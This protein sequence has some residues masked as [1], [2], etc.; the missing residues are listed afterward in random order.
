M[1][2]RDSLI[3][4]LRESLRAAPFARAAWLGGSVATGRLDEWSDIDLFII[5]ADDAVDPTLTLIEQ[6]LA[7]IAPI[8]RRFRVPEPAWHGHSQAFY[9]QFGLP[10]HLMTDVLVMKASCPAADRFLEVERHGVPTVLFDKD[11]V[12]RPEPMNAP[13]HR[14]KVA[15]KV[16]EWRLKFPMF[17][18]LVVKA[19]WRENPIEAIGFYHAFTFRPLVDMLRVRHCPDRFDYGLRYLSDDLLAADVRRLA[20]LA[21]PADPADLERKQRDAEAW[22][23]E[24]LAAIDAA[25]S[26]A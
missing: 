19:V 16:N 23:N 10:P 18:H 2:T 15:A 21:Y 7:A 22:F 12:V 20:A 26:T 3:V 17:Q 13:V 25:A 24:T 14:T 4:A 9:Q 8:E 11:G 1:I 5:A 6:T